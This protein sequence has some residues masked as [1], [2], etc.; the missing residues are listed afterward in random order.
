MLEATAWKSDLVADAIGVELTSGDGGGTLKP[1]FF[2]DVA[3]ID[4]EL[5]ISILEPCGKLRI[6][7]LALGDIFFHVTHFA[8]TQI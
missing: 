8:S 3:D 2:F 7:F 4:P 5:P 6:G 1:F